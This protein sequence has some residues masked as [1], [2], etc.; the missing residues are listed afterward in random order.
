MQWVVRPV[1]QFKL[2]LNSSAC[3]Y[4]H[5]TRVVVKTVIFMHSAVCSS[6]R[7]HHFRRGLGMYFAA[8]SWI[9]MANLPITF[10]RCLLYGNKICTMF[11]LFLVNSFFWIFYENWLLFILNNFKLRVNISVCSFYCRLRC[12]KSFEMLMF[13]KHKKQ[14]LK[15]SLHECSMLFIYFSKNNFQRNRI[16]RIS[17]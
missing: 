15:K 16:S 5:L 3:R 9:C 8:C 13:Q 10:N 1:R 6:V 2:K 17:L 11:S 14:L 4:S 12:F 7:K